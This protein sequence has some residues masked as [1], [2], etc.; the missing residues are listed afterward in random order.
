M[1]VGVSGEIAAGKTSVAR[2]LADNIPGAV[3]ASFGDFVRRE[4]GRVCGG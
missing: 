1:W 3:Y 2:A 4:A